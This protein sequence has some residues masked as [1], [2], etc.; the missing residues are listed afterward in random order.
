MTRLPIQ[1]QE[2]RQKFRGNAMRIQIDLSAEY[3]EELCPLPAFL[4]PLQW[5]DRAEEWNKCYTKRHDDGSKAKA[6][7]A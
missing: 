3:G 2:V 7:F 6:L 1:A 4:E 5:V